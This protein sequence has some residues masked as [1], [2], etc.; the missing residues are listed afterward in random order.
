MIWLWAGLVALVL[1]A[2]GLLAF[3]AGRNLGLARG[4]EVATYEGELDEAAPAG[5]GRYDETPHDGLGDAGDAQSRGGGARPPTGPAPPGQLERMEPG[6]QLAGAIALGRQAAA[7]FDR[8][9]AELAAQFDHQAA[10]EFERQASKFGQ[11]AAAA[12]ARQAA[13]EFNQQAGA[14]LTLDKP[15]PEPDQSPPDQAETAA[16]RAEFDQ[17]DRPDQPEPAAEP[18]KTERTADGSQ[19]PAS[20]G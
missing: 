19:E 14:A 5:R 6:W 3:A 9:S 12:F 17:P 10:A 16:D 1:A 8:R 18:D 4:Q 15:E 13:A 11:Q 7:E 2:V 20:Q